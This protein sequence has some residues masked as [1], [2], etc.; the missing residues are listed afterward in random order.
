MSEKIICCPK[1]QTQFDVT[2]YIEKYREKILEELKV[3]DK[4][5]DLKMKN[6]KK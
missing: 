5:K 3:F 2:K 6:E 1:C 4:L